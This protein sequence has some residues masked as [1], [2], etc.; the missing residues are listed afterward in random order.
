M[1]SRVA[2]SLSF[3]RQSISILLGRNN[4]LESYQD[5]ERNYKELL[6]YELATT[7]CENIRYK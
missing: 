6:I 2:V 4:L 7:F 3:M 1:K 5:D